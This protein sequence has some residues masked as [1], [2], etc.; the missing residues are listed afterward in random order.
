[1]REL[2]VVADNRVGLLADISETLARKSINLEGIDVEATGTKALCRILTLERD[3]E[4]A[5]KE[6]EKA[7]FEVMAS[8]ILVI[9]LVNQPGKLSEIARTLAD[10]GINIRNVH[11]L[12]KNDEFA[13]CSLDVDK[14]QLARQ[15]L[16]D[17]LQ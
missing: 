5:K 17:Y 12:T 14:N 15:L 10:K 4:T 11:L 16:A 3:E 7:G 1:M 8:D 9:K 2:F 6:L 13:L